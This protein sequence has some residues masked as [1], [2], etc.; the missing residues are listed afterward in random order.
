[1]QAP[2][3]IV[4]LPSIA[5]KYSNEKEISLVDLEWGKNTLSLLVVL[6]SYKVS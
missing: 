2:K 3:N 4:K 5:K 1:M 6:W